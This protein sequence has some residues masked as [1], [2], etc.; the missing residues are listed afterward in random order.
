MWRLW[1]WLI[2]L[3]ELVV[4]VGGLVMFVRE[5]VKGRPDGAVMAAWL[6]FVST[7]VTVRT[8]LY[9]RG[10]GSSPTGPVPESPAPESSS[11]SPT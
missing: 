2:R 4:I 3:L 9:R 1:R 7:P 6:A 11:R 5:G 10:P 8:V